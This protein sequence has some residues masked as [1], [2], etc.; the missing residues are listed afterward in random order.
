MKLTSFRHTYGEQLQT[1][2]QT[3]PFPLL[4]TPLLEIIFNENA[5]LYQ[6]VQVDG[7]WQTKNHPYVI[8]GHYDLKMTEGELQLKVTY[9]DHYR[10]DSITYE[11]QNGEFV[12]IDYHAPNSLGIPFDEA[13]TL[14]ETLIFEEQ[15]Y[16]TTVS[17]LTVILN[18]LDPDD[19]RVRRLPE[20][21]YFLG[22]AYE[23]QGQEDEA[24]A[25]YWQLWHDYPTDPYALMAAAKL[26]RQE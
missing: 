13:F 16:A 10:L 3:H 25:A 12:E 8:N 11:W 15:D 6:L 17:V 9:T 18:E 14:A 7:V 4:R 1:I 26:E 20:M 22:L 24:V 19:W 21:L 2:V 23:L 5:G